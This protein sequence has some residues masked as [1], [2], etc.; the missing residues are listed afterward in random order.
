M[1]GNDIPEWTFTLQSGYAAFSSTVDMVKA[2]AT[3]SC[4]MAPRSAKRSVEDV[5]GIDGDVVRS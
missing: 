1:V 2:S 5:Y 3:N 4:I